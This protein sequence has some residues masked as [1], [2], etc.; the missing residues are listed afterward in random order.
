MGATRTEG[1]LVGNEVEVDVIVVDVEIT[2][3]L[4]CSMKILKNQL[5]VCCCNMF[6]NFASLFLQF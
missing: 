1:D 5:K 2:G 4:L 6:L 3:D